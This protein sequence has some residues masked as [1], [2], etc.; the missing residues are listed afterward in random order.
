MTVPRCTAPARG[1]VPGSQAQQ[2]CPVHG[3]RARTSSLPAPA[4]PSTPAPK[5]ASEH[6][7]TVLSDG[8]VI[9]GWYRNSRLHREDGP[10]WVES[11]PDGTVFEGWYRNGKHHRE[12]GPAWVEHRPDG[13]VVEE[14]RKNGELHREDGP[15]C[16][17]RFPEGIV[18]EEWY[19]DGELHRE[20]GPAWVQRRPDGTVFEEW[21]RNG[22]L[23]RIDGPAQVERRPDGTVKPEAWY[24][25]DTEVGA[26]QV[27]GRYLMTRGVSGL[28]VE[29]LKQIAKD[30]PWQHWSE[31]GPD[32][33]LVALWGT[34]HPSAGIGPE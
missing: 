3:N 11:R 16:V 1:H 26:W 27:L 22:V 6:E 28:S 19:E 5:P 33:P 31:L 24:L 25:D 34:V 12:D 20:D 4:A 13:T 30:V 29:A 8:T 15:A 9:E 23:H 7:Q 17:K 10:A 18:F 2:Q 21:H 32:H 14:W